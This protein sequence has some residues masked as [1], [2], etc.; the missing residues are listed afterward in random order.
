[1][2]GLRFL[3]AFTVA[4]C[5]L[6]AAEPFGRSREVAQRRNARSIVLAID[7][8]ESMRGMDFTMDGRALSRI[9]AARRIASQ[10][11]DERRGDR[12]G[13]VAFGGRAAT[14]C[15]LTF[16]RE[17]ARVLLS[18]VEP[19]MLGKRTALGSAVALAVGRIEDDGAVV[20][21]SDGQ[22][23]AGAV[24]PAE[25]ARAAAARGVRVYT[26]G[27]GGDRPVPIP[28]RL[29]SGR[30]RLETKN[31]PLDEQALRGMADATGGAHFRADDAG[32]LREAFAA[33][34]AL[35]PRNTT[36][37]RFSRGALPATVCAAA[38]AAGLAALMLL[39][40]TVFFSAPDL[41]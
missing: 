13:L 36:R 5:I 10:F 29:P 40:A 37:A 14:Q 35:E 6:A 23:T 12:I 18:Y 3:E 8:S 33:V 28:I 9:E 34:H 39:A 38:A 19:E 20:L 22:N 24:S 27:I 32:A 16:D 4:A 26:I 30:T 21:L 1:M 11:I 15:P 31:Y 17:I 7:T 25:A 2:P 41:Q